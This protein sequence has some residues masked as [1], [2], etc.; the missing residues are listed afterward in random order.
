MPWYGA[1]SPFTQI[2][3]AGPRPYVGCRLQGQDDPDS[4]PPP[5]GFRAVIVPPMSRD[6]RL[7]DRRSDPH[8]AGLCV[9]EAAGDAYAT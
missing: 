7:A 6:D 2:D 5:G 8:S 1:A 9:E 4:A 3:R